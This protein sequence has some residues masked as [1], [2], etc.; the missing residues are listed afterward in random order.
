LA[1]EYIDSTMG[2]VFGLSTMAAAGF[3]NIISDIAGVG[4]AHYVEFAVAKFF[5]VRPPPLTAEQWDSSRTRWT[6]NSARAVGLT[7]GCLIG[8]FPLF[9]YDETATQERKLKA[10]LHS[11][12]E[13]EPAAE[14]SPVS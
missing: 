3:G 7:I 2:I 5:D 9:F 14:A 13:N 12:Q 8:M 10:K 1:G 11:Q 4:L 6:T